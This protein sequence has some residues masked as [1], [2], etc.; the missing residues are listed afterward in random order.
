MSSDGARLTVPALSDTGPVARHVHHI[1]GIQHA[2]A[3]QMIELQTGAVDGPVVVGLGIVEMVAFR[4]QHGQM[5]HVAP[6]Q[7]CASQLH[8]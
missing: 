7:M 3:E 6:R 1:S 2:V 4:R 8:E 5:L